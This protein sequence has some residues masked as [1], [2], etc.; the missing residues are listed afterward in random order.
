V[1]TARYTWT[2]DKTNTKIA[3][4]NITPVLDRRQEY[5]RDWLQHTNRMACSRLPRI[6]KN[7]QQVEEQGRPLK[8]LLDA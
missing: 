7:N 6:L 4:E 5:R 8:R 3:K 2:D 1:K